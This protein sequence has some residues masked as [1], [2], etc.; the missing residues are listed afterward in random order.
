MMAIYPLASM[1]E[2]DKKDALVRI[3]EQWKRD[4][5]YPEV[6]YEESDESR[7]VDE[8]PDEDDFHDAQNDWSFETIDSP[9]SSPTK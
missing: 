7:D 6:K 5:P 2:T 1:S 4:N 3:I 8:E 9:T